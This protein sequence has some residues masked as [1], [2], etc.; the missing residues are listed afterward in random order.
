MFHTV[1]IAMLCDWATVVLE[2]ALSIALVV[3]PASMRLA[4]IT[5]VL[6]S[7]IQIEH[8]NSLID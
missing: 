5:P 3:L 1:A 8:C 4:T 6:V 2:M 7:P